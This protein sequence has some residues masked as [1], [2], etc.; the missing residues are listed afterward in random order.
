MGMRKQPWSNENKTERI[1]FTIEPSLKEAFLKIIST[2]VSTYF[3]SVIEKEVEGHQKKVEN[4]PDAIKNLLHGQFKAFSEQV[5]GTFNYRG[6]NYPYK[7]LDVMSVEE[8]QP[9]EVI[10]YEDGLVYVKVIEELNPEK[11]VYVTL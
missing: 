3:R 9:L 1:N 8:G 6:R 10:D 7:I 2:D 4:W 5:F 11:V